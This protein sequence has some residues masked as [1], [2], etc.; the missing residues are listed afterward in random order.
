[1]SRRQFVGGSLGALGAAGMATA[2]P[3]SMQKAL[4]DVSG[5]PGSPSQIEHVNSQD[6]NPPVVPASQTLPTQEPG[7]RP[8]VP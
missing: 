1:M 4:A 7:T 3:E 2:L 6:Q 5:R 8:P